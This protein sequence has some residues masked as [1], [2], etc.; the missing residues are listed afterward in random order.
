MARAA[1]TG[2]RAAK[3]TEGIVYAVRDIVALAQEV[4]RTGREMLYLNIGDPNKFDFE[5]P[6]H[7][8]EAV[9]K[10]MLD[11][12]NSYSPSSG[13][14]TALQ[15]IEGEA[16]RNGIRSILDIFVT[17][18]GSEAIEVCLTALADP[19][20]NVLIPYPGYPLYEAVLAKLGVQ[21]KPYYLDEENGWQPD[22]EDIRRKIDPKTRAIVLI[23]PNNPTGAIFSEKVLRSILSLARS[24]G[25]VV[26][27]DEIYDKMILD[28]RRHVS[29]A[30]LDPEAPVVTFNG[31]SK[32]FL[33]PGW[34]MGWGIVSGRS[35]DLKGYLAAIN[36]ILRARLCACHPMQHAIAPALEGQKAYLDHVREKLR[37]R[38]DVTFQM[39]NAPGISTVKPEAAFYAFP[40][41]DIACSDE[42]F[43]K[44]L[45]RETGVVTVHGSGFGEKPRA[46]HLR[47]VFLPPEEKLRKAY[48]ALLEFLKKHRRQTT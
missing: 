29:T 10:A 47:V 41:L 5:T 25:L 8:I 1:L 42:D 27:S 22:I 6:P 15:A 9:H 20:E 2:I 36:K 32:S 24:R 4:A 17:S 40:K 12:H 48:S 34:R 19:G 11:N 16:G 26:F 7:L 28:G 37:R 30:S 14:P 18:G 45:I 35:A 23:N 13:I 38:R 3:R 44:A 31:L 21:P 39:L 33:A 43:V 46:K